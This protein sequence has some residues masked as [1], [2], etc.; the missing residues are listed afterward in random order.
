MAAGLNVGLIEQEIVETIIQMACLCR[1]PG[2]HQRSERGQGGLRPPFWVANSEKSIDQSPHMTLFDFSRTSTRIDAAIDK[3]LAERLIVG[4]I[5]LIAQNGE[6]VLSPRG[7]LCGS[8]IR[9]G[10]AIH[11]ELKAG[12]GVQPGGSALMVSAP[13]RGDLSNVLPNHWARS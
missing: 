7:R 9:N 1:F 13:K 4:T 3:A 5:V 11:H 8:R 10:D 2:G 12:I 6:I